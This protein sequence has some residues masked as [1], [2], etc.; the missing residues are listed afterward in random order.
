MDHFYAFDDVRF[1]FRRVLYDSR[2]DS[3]DSLNAHPDYYD[4][5]NGFM[6]FHHS[7]VLLSV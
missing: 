7:F 4:E 3:G 1:D 6:N 5:T 2:D